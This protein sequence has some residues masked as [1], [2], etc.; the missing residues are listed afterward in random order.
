MRTLFD[1]VAPRRTVG[2]M[3]THIEAMTAPFPECD[4]ADIVEELIDRAERRGAIDP[5]T[6]ESLRAIYAEAAFTLA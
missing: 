3:V 4:R 2:E 6:A 5:T 1:T